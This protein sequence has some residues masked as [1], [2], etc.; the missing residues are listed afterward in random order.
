MFYD[1][2]YNYSSF[3]IYMPTIRLWIWSNKLHWY[4]L[5]Y[6]VALYDSGF[7]NYSPVIPFIDLGNS[8]GTLTGVDDGSSP[9]IYLPSPLRVGRSFVT[10]AY[11]SI[12]YT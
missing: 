8:G 9:V 2:T 3:R 12:V 6:F 11:V 7:S 4:A 1:Y 10:T 5:W